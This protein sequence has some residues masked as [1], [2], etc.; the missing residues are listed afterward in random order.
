MSQIRVRFAPSPTG[1]LHIGGAR[2]ALYNWLFARKHN[3]VFILRIEDTDT[4][5][6]TQASIDEILDGLRWLGI[7]WDEGPYFQ[8]HFIAEHQ[9][10]AQQLLER[11]HAYKC[12]CTK[13]ELEAKR[14]EALRKKIDYKYDKACRKL[15]PQEIKEREK[16]EIPY[17]VRFKVPESDGSVVFDD[18]VYGRIEKK[19]ADIEDFVILRSDGKPLYVLSNAVDDYRDRI[20]HVFRGQD[21]LANTPKQILIYNALGYELPQF[22]HMSLTLDTKKAKIS[23]RKH[24]DVV[25]VKY[26]KEHGFLPWALCNFLAL[27]GWSNS[28]SRELFTR[29]ELIEAFDISGI[30][31]SN[32]IFN[33]TPGDPKNWTDPKAIAINARHMSMMDVRELAPYVRDEL[34]IAGLWDERYEH[35]LREWFLSTIDLIRTRFHTLKDFATLGRPYFSDDF[36]YDEVAVQKNLKKDPQL[37]EYLLQLADRF[38]RLPSFTVEASEHEVRQLSEQLGIKAGILINAVRTAVTGQAAGPGL[39]ELLRAIGKERV[40]NRLRKAAHIFFQ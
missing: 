32:A 39:F 40:V 6:S 16:Q 5:R 28:E 33:Y 34:R 38:E 22:A 29:E 9:K 23:K 3:G 20:T 36:S 25:T 31:K 19:Y 18:L 17:V 2:T 21:G 10:A 4:D 7:T 12:F 37:K 35:E 8:S 24:G 1:Y 27:L 11:G 13:E 26:Y 30:S 14:D 15:S